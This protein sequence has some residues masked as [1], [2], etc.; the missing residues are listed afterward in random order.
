MCKEAELV[1]EVHV[2][3]G[4]PLEDVA[5]SEGH[6]ELQG[7]R[8]GGLIDG[9]GDQHKEV[10]A[11]LFEPLVGLR[12]PSSMKTCV[13]MPVYPR[14]VATSAAKYRFSG[15]VTTV[16]VV[17]RTPGGGVAER[18]LEQVVPAAGLVRALG[19]GERAPVLSPKP[20]RYPLDRGR[21]GDYVGQILHP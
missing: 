17:K 5:A 16:A 19:H 6:R 3:L 8:Q 7:R 15:V 13:G 12:E 4:Q 10:G 2:K 11:G 1:D 14:T 21:V 18:V 9:V 20:P